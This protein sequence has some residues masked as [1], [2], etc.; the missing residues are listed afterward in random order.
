MLRRLGFTGRVMAIVMLALLALWAIGVAL[1]FLTETREEM[2]STFYPL[3]EQ[4]AAIVDLIDATPPERRPAV[5]KAVSSEMLRVTIARERPAVEVGYERLPRVEQFLTRYLGTLAPREVI[6]TI[7][8]SHLPRWRELRFGQY[9]VYARQPVYLVVSLKGGGY[10][11]F[12]TRGQIGRRLFGVPP[13][14]WVGALGALVGIAAIIA[15]AREA[16]PLRRLADSVAGFSGNAPVAP[17]VP[18]GAP[19]IRKLIEAINAM[20]RRIVD[21]VRARTL[22]LGAISHDLKTYITRLRLRIEQLPVDDQRAKAA[23]DL[24]EMT[25]LI[26]DALVVSRGSFAPARREGVDLRE[27]LARLTADYPEEKVCFRCPPDLSRSQTTG[28][29]VA[30]RR[31]FAN[32]ID[33]ALQFGTLCEVALARRGEELVVTIDDDGPGIPARER[34]AVLEPFYRLEPSRSR[35]TGGSGLGLAIVKQ[36]VEAHGGAIAIEASPQGGTRATVTLPAAGGGTQ[37]AGRK[38]W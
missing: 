3:P 18:A 10:A 31:L 30:L 1:I 23:R 2:A 11:V 21:L 38:P 24:D 28:E 36:I 9:W 34:Q 13:G 25:R 19:E 33:N 12:E 27:L 4:V 5:L 15:I 26:D 37:A 8:P 35:V 17:M 7:E 20:Q 6:A 16:R 22:L 32:L 29:P 14:F